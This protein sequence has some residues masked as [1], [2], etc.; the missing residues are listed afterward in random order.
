L[1]WFCSSG[2]AVGLRIAAARPSK[3]SP[4]L[5]EGIVTAQR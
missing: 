4:W 1:A 2:R 5:W 3:R